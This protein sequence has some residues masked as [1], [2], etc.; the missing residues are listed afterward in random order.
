[1]FSIRRGDGLKPSDDPWDGTHP[2]KPI[3]VQTRRPAI[4][5]TI[6]DVYKNVK[7]IAAHH[8]GGL[9]DSRMGRT[10]YNALVAWSDRSTQFIC[11]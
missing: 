3:D 4:F 7:E 5:N 11:N 2:R 8:L 9:I 10:A 6:A 1:M